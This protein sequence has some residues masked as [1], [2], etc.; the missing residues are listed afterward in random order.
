MTVTPTTKA[1]IFS[2]LGILTLI[3]SSIYAMGSSGLNV[4]SGEILI[5]LFLLFAGFL[6][7]PSI[8]F[9]LALKIVKSFE[10]EEQSTMQKVAIV[11]TV[12]LG[13]A[14]GVIIVGIIWIIIRQRS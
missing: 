5:F 8:F 7:V 1:N 2:S 11:S 14:L 4:H 3:A 9:M 6:I 10:N 13:L 12:I